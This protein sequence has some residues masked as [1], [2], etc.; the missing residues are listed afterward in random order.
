MNSAIFIKSYLVSPVPVG[1]PVFSSN[2]SSDRP[3]D[4]RAAA[5]A[6]ALATRVVVFDTVPLPSCLFRLAGTSLPL[7]AQW[8][9]RLRPCGQEDRHCKNQQQDSS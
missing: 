9:S 2:L 1:L 3:S 8:T 7:A 5:A 4:S 6:A